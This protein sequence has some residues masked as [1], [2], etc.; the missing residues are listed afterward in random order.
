MCLYTDGVEV[1]LSKPLD[2]WKVFERVRDGTTFEPNTLLAP[3][4]RNQVYVEGRTYSESE[5]GNDMESSDG[6]SLR[7]SGY[8][9][10]KGLYAYLTES[11][12]LDVMDALMAVV[13][14]ENRSYV[15]KKCRI[16]K[17]SKV[18]Y[19]YDGDIAASALTIPE[20]TN[21]VLAYL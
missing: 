2:V 18:F 5:L 10:K 1:T 17:D 15:V 8:M 3:Y 7:P 4:M 13:V 6:L 14:S 21:H 16:P 11:A 19:G 20:E 9:L 12:A